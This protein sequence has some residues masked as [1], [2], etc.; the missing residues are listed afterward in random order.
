MEPFAIV[1]FSFK[2]PQDAIDESSFWEVLE[3]RKSLMTEWP[4]NRASIE[5]FFDRGSKN[6]N[7][8]CF[9]LTSSFHVFPD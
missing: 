6:L 9:S 5:S 8:V 7:T 1:G 3:N 2:M 4:E